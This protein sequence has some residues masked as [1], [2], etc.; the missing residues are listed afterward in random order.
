MRQQSKLGVVPFGCTARLML[1][2][3]H[4][5]EWVGDWLCAASRAQRGGRGGLAGHN[6]ER[7]LPLQRS[8]GVGVLSEK[9]QSLFY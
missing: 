9:L 1:R 2:L 8:G 6:A 3:A 7:T 4:D 5:A